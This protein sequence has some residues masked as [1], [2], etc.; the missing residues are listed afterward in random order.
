MAQRQRLPALSPFEEEVGFTRALRDG[1]RILVS[2]TV[3]IEADGSVAEDA[4]AQADRCFAL[5]LGYIEEL[6]GR[7]EDLVRIRMFVTDI[8][9][10]DKVSASFARHCKVARPTATLVAIAALY[11][12]RWKVEIEAEAIVE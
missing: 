9:D 11:D 3:G 5:I 1:N 7:A 10:A 6:G 4:G 8:A 2:G 12:P